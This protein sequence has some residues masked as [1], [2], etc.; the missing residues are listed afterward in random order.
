MFSR[1]CLFS[2]QNVDIIHIPAASAGAVEED[3]E[4]LLGQQQPRY[5]SGLPHS[6]PG[7]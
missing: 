2:L 3:D 5:Q 4:D 7:E 6:K 1:S